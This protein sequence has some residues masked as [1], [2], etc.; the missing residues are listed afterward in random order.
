MTPLRHPPMLARGVPKC[1][2]AALIERIFR[3]NPA[4]QLVPVRSLDERDKTR[5]GLNEFDPEY[6]DVLVP[7]ISGLSVK[8][9]NRETA[10]LLMGLRLAGPLPPAARQSFAEC[11]EILA[12]LVLDSVLEILSGEQFISGVGASEA[13]TLPAFEPIAPTLI[14]RLSSQALEYGEA[15]PLGHAPALSARLYFYNRFPASPT[16]MRRLGSEQAVRRYLN[17]APRTATGALLSSEWTELVVSG[18]SN[19]WLSWRHRSHERVHCRYKMYVN[20]D[21]V[22]LPATLTAVLR[23]ATELGVPSFKIG[24]DL[25]GLLRPDKLI[26]YLDSLDRVAELAKRLSPALGGARVQGTPFSAAIDPAGLLS[27]GMDPPRHER[28]ST[29]QGTSWRRWITDRLAIALLAAKTAGSQRP[30]QKPRCYAVQRLHLE[31]VDTR[32]WTPIG[33]NWVGSGNEGH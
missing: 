26:L 5:F 14:G 17:L 33:V 24:A 13:V 19:G 20:V 2:A 7:A 15:L 11:P 25:F 28:L 16:L 10:D 12:R 1:G 8:A 29:W 4:Y 9:V 3:F 6:A 27:W 18:G 31:G 23:V 22:D 32:T 30:K 21:I